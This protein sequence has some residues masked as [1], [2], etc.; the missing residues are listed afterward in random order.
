MKFRHVLCGLSIATVA[1]TVTTPTT[2]ESVADFYKGKTITII[3]GVRAGGAYDL[4][5]RF[6]GDHATKHIPGHPNIIYQYMPGG[7]GVKSANYLYNVA[8][9]NGTVIGMLEQG[10]AVGKLLR[11]HPNMKF[12][13]TKFNWVGTVGRSYYLFGVWHKAPATTVEGAKKVEVL[14]AASGKASTTYIYPK[15]A[16]YIVGTKYKPVLGYRGAGAMN[17]SFMR[18]ETHGR[19]GT[20]S[21][22]K[23]K[24][25]PHI[26]SGELKFALQIAPSKNPEWPDVPLLIDLAKNKA[27]RD[28]VEFMTVPT[29]IGR[30][31][32]LPPGVPKERVAAIRRA[33]DA[34]MRDSR[35]LTKAKKLGVRTTGESGEELQALMTKLAATPPSVVKNVRDAIGMQ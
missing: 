3:V 34:T 17:L 13:I 12:D 21:S 26:K 32:L 35:V 7:G 1:A 5:A 23:T 15:L 6:F 24:M 28:I 22:W 8:P 4:Y 30:S 16:N 27:D 25:G 18:G 14:M 9:K 20:W 11:D 19:G 33:F 31:L 10:T 2:A 29:A